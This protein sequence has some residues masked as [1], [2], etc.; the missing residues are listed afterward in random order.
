MREMAMST[1]RWARWTD[2]TRLLPGHLKDQSGRIGRILLLGFALRIVLLP[3]F[4]GTDAMSTAWISTVLMAKGQLILSNDPPPIFYVHALVFQMFRPILPAT[5]LGRFTSS[6][7]FTP[8]L[9][10]QESVLTEPGIAVYLALLKLPYLVFDLATAVLFLWAIREPGTAV[11]VF[12]LW[13]FNPVVLFATYFIGQFDVVAVFFVVLAFYHNQQG[14]RTSTLV[15]LVLAILFKVF[16]IVIV[17]LFLFQWLEKDRGLVVRAK[18][19]AKVAVASVTP[20]VLQFLIIIL[21][22]VFYES[23]NY[24]LTGGDLNG[25]YGTTIYNRGAAANPL[26]QGFFTFVG[27][28]SR[29]SVSSWIPDVFY[30]LPIAYILFLVRWVTLRG[31]DDAQLWNATAVLFLLVYAFSLFHAQWFLWAQPFLLLLVA[32]EGKRFTFLY[33]GI[34]LLFFV[35]IWLWDALLTSV[36]LVPTI[37]AAEGWPGPITLLYRAGLP[38]DLILNLAR[39]AFSVLCLVLA[40]LCLRKAWLPTVVTKWLRDRARGIRAGR[41]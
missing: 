25:F 40:F 24:A 1:P 35:Y 7:A 22:P 16:A 37:P 11:R 38:A 39:T 26:L 5:I 23:A 32:R 19:F 8:S 28:S 31:K 41:S 2:W 9:F 34:V 10:L 36:L 6:V 3:L 14:R 33:A 21:Q 15:A 17:P 18:S 4:A 13:L 20:F 27:Y 30:V 29:I 12:K